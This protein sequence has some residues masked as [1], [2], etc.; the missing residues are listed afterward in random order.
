MIP[1]TA[2]GSL[3]VE[4][5]RECGCLECQLR[6]VQDAQEILEMHREAV[7]RDF[8][9]GTLTNA[10]ADNIHAQIDERLE[11]C[12]TRRVEIAFALDCQREARERAASQERRRDWRDGYDFDDNVVVLKKERPDG[13]HPNGG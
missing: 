10:E 11:H 2:K 6:R 7:D 13:T 1:C 5:Y 9:S 4:A 12:S 8:A 3:L